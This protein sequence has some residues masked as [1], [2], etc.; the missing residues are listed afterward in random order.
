MALLVVAFVLPSAPR[1][2]PDTTQSGS[3]YSPDAPPNAKAQSLIKTQFQPGSNTAG[4][5]GGNKL[6]S[7]PPPPPVS[8]PPVKT[9]S[10][11]VQCATYWSPP[12]QWDSVYA[13]PCQAAF[14]GDN[15]GN[16]Q[17]GVTSTQYNMVVSFYGQQQTDGVINDASA[18]QSDQLRTLNDIQTYHTAHAMTYN[19]KLQLAYAT[20][21]RATDQESSQRSDVTNAISKY[22]P[23][24]AEIEGTAPEIDEYTKNHVVNDSWLAPIE[25]FFQHQKP[26][27]WSQVSPTFA[28]KLAS[29]WVCKQLKGHPPIAGINTGNTAW[30]PK[31]DRTWGSI[32]IPLAWANSGPTLLSGQ[33]VKVKGTINYVFTL[34]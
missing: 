14:I 32:E 31:K 9:G 4:Q 21:A 25:S 7:P 12:R 1:P 2:P 34:P 30:D 33:P 16:L 29:E 10:G 17:P 19:R 28:A 24:A 27:A 5:E 15:G 22:H 23:I 20:E 26:Y 11:T 13:P 8:P 6:P 18:R 3:E